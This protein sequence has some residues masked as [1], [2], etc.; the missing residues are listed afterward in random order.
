MGG[1]KGKERKREGMIGKDEVKW[2][3]VGKKEE[4][5][6]RERERESR[7][8]HRQR[9]REIVCVYVLTIV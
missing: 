5:R 9:E 4:K 7:D 6:Q 2:Q 8:T 3:R 1:R